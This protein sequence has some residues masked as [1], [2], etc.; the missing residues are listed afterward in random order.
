MSQ[1]ALAEQ[2]YVSLTTARDTLLS[3][4]KRFAYDRL[5]PGIATD[6]SW[7]RHKSIRDFAQAGLK[8]LVPAYISSAVGLWAFTWLGLLD[9]RGI[10]W[11]YLALAALAAVEC[12]A[13]TRPWHSGITLAPT[14]LN[15]WVRAVVNTLPEGF[16]RGVLGWGPGWRAAWV[17]QRYLPFQALRVA[18]RALVAFFIALSRLGPVLAGAGSEQA[19]GGEAA[20][21]AMQVSRLEQLVNTNAIESA[22]LLALEAVPFRQG[23]TAEGAPGTVGGDGSAALA[24]VDRDPGLRMLREK[25]KEWFITNTIRQDPEVRQAVERVVEEKRTE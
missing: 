8:A 22:R 17:R 19:G 7:A 24:A 15:P 11:R 10:Y 18:H 1:K 9:A 23:S 14:L 21:L 25:I 12:H 13:I 6:A 20:Q 16:A 3:P 2:H 5:G 4:A